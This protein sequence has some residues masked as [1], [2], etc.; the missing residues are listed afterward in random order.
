MDVRPLESVQE[1]RFEFTPQSQT[2]PASSGPAPPVIPSLGKRGLK[3]P[4]LPRTR[5]RL[6]CRPSRVGAS[7]TW[8]EVRTGRQFGISLCELRGTEGVLS[9]V[10]PTSGQG[11]GPD[12]PCSA[13]ANV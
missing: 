2:S 5:P 7:R 9:R 12:A 11:V 10:A 8:A 13:D 6:A 1:R 3:L 4:R